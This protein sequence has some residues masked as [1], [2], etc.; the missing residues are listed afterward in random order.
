M[1]ALE[2]R[3]VLKLVLKK[4]GQVIVEFVHFGQNRNHGGRGGGGS[5]GC[6]VRLQSPC[7][8]H[9]RFADT[10][11]TRRRYLTGQYRRRG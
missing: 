10:R 2:R 8:E 4:K 9:R 1:E 11:R 3:K 5:G 6:V 7:N